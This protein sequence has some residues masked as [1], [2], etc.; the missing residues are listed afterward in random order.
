M[1]QNGAC[2]DGWVSLSGRCFKLVTEPTKSWEAAKAACPS[3]F[4]GS[5]LAVVDF[6]LT[7]DSSSPLLN[8]YAFWVGL[9]ST[10]SS[11]GNLYWS[12]SGDQV[13]E[14]HWL[15]DKTY[16]EPNGSAQDNCVFVAGLTSDEVFGL[17]DWGDMGCD[18]EKKGYLCQLEV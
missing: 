16:T 6:D 17:G 8:T 15:S 1:F 5:R 18:L 2:E 12:T 11:D 7:Q 3:D 4:P 10:P 14:T 13:T 9:K